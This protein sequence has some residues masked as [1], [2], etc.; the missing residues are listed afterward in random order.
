MVLDEKQ[1]Q[2]GRD[3]FADAVRIPRR[4]MLTG[5]VAVPTAAAMYYGYDHLQGEPVKAGL[6]GTGNQGCYA[7][8]AQSNPEFV[9]IVAYSDI[10]PANQAK[11]RQYFRD[12]Y[13][14]EAD[15]V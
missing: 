13:G 4:Q 14:A 1:R 6:I 7:H 2:I 12:K 15:Q 8:I 10:R 5:A 11:A 9:K 3:N